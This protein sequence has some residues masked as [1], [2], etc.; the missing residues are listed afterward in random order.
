MREEIKNWFEQGKR[1][2]DN[3]EY[4][5]K[6]ERLEAAAFYCQQSIE[7]CFNALIMFSKKESPGPIHSLIKLASIIKVPLQF[8]PFLRALNA[9]YI[10][11]R[12]PDIAEGVP[13][14]QYTKAVVEEYIKK[15]KELIKWISTQI[16]E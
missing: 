7:K 13:Y 6:D 9:E 10:F 14:K 4:L 3:A 15:S 1:D 11:S 12:Y 5:L 2:L 16:K 8:Y